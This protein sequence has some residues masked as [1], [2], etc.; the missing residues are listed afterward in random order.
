MYIHICLYI[1]VYVY[2][3]VYIIYIYTTYVYSCYFPLL[4]C[5]LHPGPGQ[6][7]KTVSPA[8]GGAA[9]VST[10]STKSMFKYL[11]TNKNLFEY[12]NFEMGKIW[13]N[14]KC[15]HVGATIWNIKSVENVGNIRS[16]CLLWRYC[17]DSVAETTQLTHPVSLRCSSSALQFA[18]KALVLLNL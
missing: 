3:Y 14:K 1:Y 6:S 10:S 2:V 7:V 13:N 12:L 9:C 16:V 15:R 4:K 17:R 18:S 8:S 11:W 5:D